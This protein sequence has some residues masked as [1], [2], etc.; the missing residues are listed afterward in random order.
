MRIPGRLLH[1]F[2][3]MKKV[4]IALMLV[5]STSSLALAHPPTDIVINV[6]KDTQKLTAVVTHPVKDVKRHHIKKV[7]I[8]VNGKEIATLEFTQQDNL[9][10]QSV[11]YQLKDVRPGDVVE[12]EG[13]CSIFGKLAREVKVK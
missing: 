10:S 11:T 12:V 1:A 3:E 5:L 13:Y 9:T 4:T 6:D 2:N 8:A 7:D